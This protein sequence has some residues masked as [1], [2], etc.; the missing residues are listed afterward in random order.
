MKRRYLTPCIYFLVLVMACPTWAGP[1]RRS[2]GAQNAGIPLAVVPVHDGQSDNVADELRT[3]IAAALARQAAIHVVAQDRVAEVMAYHEP[4]NTALAADPS[5]AQAMTLQERAK[6][7]FLNFAGAEARAEIQGALTQIQASRLPLADKGLVLRD[8]LVTAAVIAA[9]GKDNAAAE[10]YFEETLKIDP[11]YILDGS[12]FSP[13]LREIF[14]RVQSRLLAATG[15]VSISSSPKVADVYING[16]S[17][18]VAPL[19]VQLPPGDYDVRVAGNRY[20]PFNQQLQIRAGETAAVKATLAWERSRPRP[21]AT[22]VE[23]EEIRALLSEGQRLMELLRLQKVVLLDV[24][25]T[26]DGGGE[27]RVRMMDAT[28]QASHRPVHVRFRADRSTLPKDM[29]EMV[30]LLT[31]QATMKRIDNPVAQLDP[32]GVGDPIVMGRRKRR[33]VTPLGWGVIGGVAGGG[34]IAGILAAVLS[35]GGGSAPGSGTG[36]IHVQLSQ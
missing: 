20:T 17:K 30:K 13:R 25:S 1:V 33:G 10:G 8:A 6:E 14:S 27:I 7:H 28:T 21:S 19:T 12:S 4:V 24:D 23:T 31:A 2:S 9:D 16:I 18:G 29:G 22:S 11:H 15:S 34:A 26:P 32:A 36:S 5:L 3:A 35:G